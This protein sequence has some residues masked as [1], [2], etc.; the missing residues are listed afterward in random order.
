MCVKQ[1]FESY[2]L[3]VLDTDGI[4]FVFWKYIEEE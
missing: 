3:P 1:A 4:Q 2:L